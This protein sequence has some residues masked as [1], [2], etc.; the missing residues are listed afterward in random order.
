MKNKF[1]AEEYIKFL[2]QEVQDEIPEDHEFTDIYRES[3]EIKALEG[4]EDK[5]FEAILSTP[6]IDRDKEIVLSEGIDAKAFKKNPILLWMHNWK[7]PPIGSVSK[8]KQNSDAFSI[9]ANMADTDFALDLWKLVKGGHLRQLSMG[10]LPTEVWLPN[11]EKFMEWTKSNRVNP[12]N[13][14]L[15]IAKSYLLEASLV[16]LPSNTDAE[17]LSIS[18][19]FSPETMK[20]LGIEVHEAPPIKTTKLISRLIKG[21]DNTDDYVQKC[22]QEQLDILSGKI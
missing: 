1:S 10:F 8:V 19:S 20:M 21:P 17:I 3:Y 16:T 15:I 4:E 5:S 2:P 18:K 13:V 9:K 12:K 6:K 14:N 22:I 7:E 11:S